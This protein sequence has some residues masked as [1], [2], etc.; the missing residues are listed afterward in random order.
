[1]SVTSDFRDLLYFLE[2]HEARYLVIGGY[3]FAFHAIPR[4]TKDLDLFVDPSPGNVVRA[5]KALADFGAPLLL[6]S[7]RPGDIVQLGIEPSRVDLLLEIG[8]MDFETAWNSRVRGTYGDVEVN[9]VGIEGLIQSKRIAGRPRDLE[10][11]ET[12]ERILSSE[13]PHDEKVDM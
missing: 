4:Y 5:N 2:K 1:M 3:A 8:P 13:E 9:W 11:V 7:R 12:L 6:D 10:D